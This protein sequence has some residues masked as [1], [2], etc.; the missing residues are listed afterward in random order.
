MTQDVS[1]PDRTRWD[2]AT[3]AY[4]AA[5][6]SAN[7]RLRA[8][9]ETVVKIAEREADVKLPKRVDAMTE[10]EFAIFAAITRTHG[11]LL[12]IG[13]RAAHD[14]EH[15][16]VVDTDMAFNINDVFLFHTT[17]AGTRFLLQHA[18]E[19]RATVRASL[20]GDPHG[21]ITDDAYIPH[22]DDDGRWEM[23]AWEF[24]NT[25]GPRCHNGAPQLIENNR[26]TIRG[27]C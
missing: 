8:T 25:F 16:G 20:G 19:T 14:L 12:Y 24:F 22:R 5:L 7:S 9:L 3:V 18:G 26:I 21:I 13:Q 2:D 4:V 23:Q 27:M 1:V 15:V 17:D 10:D 6:E 11:A